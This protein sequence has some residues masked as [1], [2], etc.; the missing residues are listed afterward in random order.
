MNPK[1]Q[2]KIVSSSTVHV[3]PVLIEF[4]GELEPPSTHT[5]LHDRV[6]LCRQCMSEENREA[7]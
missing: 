1:D 7:D 5:V 3:I 4:V 2:R 6:F